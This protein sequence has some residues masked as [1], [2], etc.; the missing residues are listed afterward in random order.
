MTQAEIAAAACTSGIGKVTNPIQLLQ[1]I[2]QLS[3][4]YLVELVPGTN[5]TVAAITTRACTSGIG[6]VTEPQELLRIIAQLLN[7]QQA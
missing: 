7:D 3:A 5:V 1:I 2:A 4:D 6:K